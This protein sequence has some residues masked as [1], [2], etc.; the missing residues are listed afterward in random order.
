[1][2]GTFTGIL[3]DITDFT[4]AQRTMMEASASPRSAAGNGRLKATGTGGPTNAIASWLRP[5]DDSSDRGGLGRRS[6]NPTTLPWTDVIHT[7]GM[8]AEMTAANTAYRP[9]GRMMRTWQRVKLRLPPAIRRHG[10]NIGPG[11]VVR[12]SERVPG[13]LR[14]WNRLRSKPRMR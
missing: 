9:S 8:T 2:P 3:W 6:L 11:N 13:L 1:M 12:V 5:G 7:G 4:R 14:R 10:L